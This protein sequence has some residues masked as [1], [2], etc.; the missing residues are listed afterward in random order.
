MDFRTELTPNKADFE[1][2]HS[3]SILLMGSCFANNIGQKLNDYHFDTL[4]NPLG[5]A[6]NPISLFQLLTIEDKELENLDIQFDGEQYYSYQLHSKFNNRSNKSFRNEILEAKRQLHGQLAKTNYIFISLGTAWVHQLLSDDSIVN[7]CQKQAANLFRKSLL[8]V[9]SIVDNTL[10][11]IDTMNERFKKKFH[12]IFT[13]SP[14]RHLKDGFKENQLSKSTLHLAVDEICKSNFN[15][16]YFPSYEIM[17]DDLRD[18]RFYDVDLLHPNQ[19]AIEFI[20]QFFSATYFSESTQSINQKVI[21]LKQSLKHKAFNP[22]SQKHQKFLNK[23]LGD[24][25]ELTNKYKLD[26]SEEIATIKAQL[27]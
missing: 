14:I 4:I 9:E 23:L 16:S 6:Y 25:E 8:S 21:K 7:N 5:I 24:I 2:D 17:L 20:W 26:F 18:Y 15:T 12:F 13:I 1:I 3:D 11:G 27:Q 22:E 10:K 19:T